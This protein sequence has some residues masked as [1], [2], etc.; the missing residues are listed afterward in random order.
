MVFNR[1]LENYISQITFQNILLSKLNNFFDDFRKYF[2]NECNQIYDNQFEA[3]SKLFINK[4]RDLIKDKENISNLINNNKKIY[5]FANKNYYYFNKDNYIFN[6]SQT[7]QT[8]IDTIKDAENEYD[9]NADLNNNEN[10]RLNGSINN[11]SNINK[12]E[13]ESE[14]ESEEIEKEI[15]INIKDSQ[16]IN[17]KIIENRFIIQKWSSY[18]RYN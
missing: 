7:L 2:P 5:D 13:E 17:K 10:I 11:I 12:D 16:I 8:L 6:N 9:L 14:N 3:I 15:I 4:T 1:Y 18:K